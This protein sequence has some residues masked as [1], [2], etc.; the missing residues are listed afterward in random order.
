V[1]V[2][3]DAVSFSY[4]IKEVY[5]CGEDADTDAIIRLRFFHFYRVCVH[6]LS[7]SWTVKKVY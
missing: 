2:L 3:G 7:K 5:R 4:G 6:G 1:V